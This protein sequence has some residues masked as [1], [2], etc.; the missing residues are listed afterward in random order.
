MCGIAG[1]AGQEWTPAEREQLFAALAHRG[2][3]D[4]GHFSAPEVTLMHLRLSIL[5]TSP[6]GAQPMSSPDGRYSLIHNGEIYNFREIQ[7]QLP[8]QEW[9][10]ETDTEV[11]LAA[12]AHWGKD[13]LHRLN[14]MFALA[15]WDQ[16]ERTLLVARDRMGIK[17]LYFQVE[18]GSLRF[19]SEV[20]AL[21]KIG[22]RPPRLNHSALANYLCYMTTYGAQSLVEGVEMLGA[23]EY[24]V[25]KL[26]KIERDS[27]WKPGDFNQE[28]KHHDRAQAQK[29]VLELLSK[30]V[31]RRMLS[32]VPLGAFLSG[33]IDSSAI[34]ALM[35]QAS[36]QP[37]DTFSVIF[38]E[39]EFDESPWSQMVADRYNTR[40]HP[41]L[42]KPQDFLDQLPAALAA[43]DHPSG[44]G[45]NSYV[46]AGVT[47]AQG[48]TVALSGLG[49]DELF[50]GYPVFTQLPGI[51]QSAP[52]RL[53][54][55]LRR[56]LGSVYG[57][58]RKGR[59]AAKKTALLK[60][61]QADFQRVYPVYRTIFDWPVSKQLVGQE[62][63]GHPLQGI[64]AEADQ[65]SEMLSKVS[66][67][68]IR[69]YTQSVLLR[70]M[71]QMSMAHA[72]EARV[73]FFD[74]ELVEYVLGIP[75]QVKWPG[76]PKQLLVE[77]MGDLLP[78]EVVHRKKMGFVFPWE[79]WLRGELKAWAQERWKRLAERGIVDPNF[80][81]KVWNEFQRGQGPWLW[82]HIWVWV[83]LEDWMERNSVES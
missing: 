70:D 23:G 36:D 11:I 7:A 38:Q 8:A 58:F 5:D 67:G 2:P 60:L 41:I 32:D 44:D 21:M 59:Q 30:A 19:A 24:M 25:W 65:F 46:V 48:I 20:R 54:A 9:K 79:Q 17:P 61:P 81:M 52:M 43:M 12:Y 3:D 42:L 51:L 62:G 31:E 73:P 69:S 13:F 26:G 76:Y 37:V 18:N 80:L 16:E 1:I 45:I 56:L 6:R 68:E 47:R 10:T 14:G 78:G 15:I 35:A 57:T 28:G 77:A 82:I 33:G 75:D 83:V 66:W 50:A 72:L 40:H 55:P 34:V 71:D 27:F 64:V 22:S 74:H 39:K 63:L 4:R 53:P 49:G 29:R